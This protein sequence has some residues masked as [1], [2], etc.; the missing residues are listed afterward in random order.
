MRKTEIW[1]IA[2]L[3]TTATL[4]PPLAASEAA[5]CAEASTSLVIGLSS[6]SL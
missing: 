5:A 4:L 2:L 1:L 3:W 6:V